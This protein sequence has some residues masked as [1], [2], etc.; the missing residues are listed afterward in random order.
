[1]FE[2]QYRVTLLLVNR[3]LEEKRYNDILKVYDSFI[4][5]LKKNPPEDSNYFELFGLITEALLEKVPLDKIIVIFSGS[6]NVIF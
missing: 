6:L 2:F 4:S 5:H 3:L 1:L